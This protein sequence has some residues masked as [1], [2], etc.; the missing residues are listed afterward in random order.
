MNARE[1]KSIGSNPALTAKKGETHISFRIWLTNTSFCGSQENALNIVLFFSGSPFAN[2]T[3]Q[4]A[5]E[6][7]KEACN[8]SV[9]GGKG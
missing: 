7:Q 4:E 9:S 3:L 6:G 1:N 5:K 8:Y 2:G